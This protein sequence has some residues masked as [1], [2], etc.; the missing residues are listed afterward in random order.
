VSDGN[1]SKGLL[2]VSDV[3]QRFG[4]IRAVNGATFDVAPQS[5]TALIGPNGAGK[6]TLFNVVT[7]FYKGNQGSVR[8]D[9]AE[10]F[11]E[12]PYA[13]ANRGMVRTFQI[14]KALAAMPVID[15]MMLAAPDQPGERFYNLLIR[16][17]AVRSREKEVREEAMELL[18][19]FNLTKLADAYAGTLSGG[20]RKLLELARALMAKP[21]LLLLDEPMAGINPT[22]GKRLLDH[23]QRLRK[24]E[25]VTFLFIEHDMEV[26]MNHSD[27]VVVMA[28]GRVIASGDPQSVRTDQKVIDAYLGGAAHE[29][30][31]G[32]AAKAREAAKLAADKVRKKD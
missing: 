14:T 17:A 23:M 24:E 32:K 10:V 25:G 30:P 16:P 12:A 3:Y 28:E 31:K 2:Q 7:G 20:Q 19:V 22:L 21:K 5:I 6:T 18:D 15:N 13:I 27:K 8:F 4:G 29:T 1:G 11:R 26:V 9:G